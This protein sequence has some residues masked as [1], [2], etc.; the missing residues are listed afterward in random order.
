MSGSGIS[1]TN[2]RGKQFLPILVTV[3]LDSQWLSF[4]NLQCPFKCIQRTSEAAV[5]NLM[6]SVYVP[7]N[8]ATQAADVSEGAGVGVGGYT[9]MSHTGNI[10]GDLA[11]H[12]AG[13]SSMGSPAV[14]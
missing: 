12:R 6:P 7:S 11:L 1:S 4:R 3:T 2:A 13:S 10:G 14:L 9:M 5:Q 8:R